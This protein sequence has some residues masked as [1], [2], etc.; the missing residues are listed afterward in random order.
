MNQIRFTAKD[1]EWSEGLKE[2]V[3]QKIIE[4]LEHHLRDQAFDLRVELSHETRGKRRHAPS[5]VLLL[6]L[7]T[8]DGRASHAL[9]ERG[10]DAYAL[11]NEVSGQ[12]GA[13]LRKKPVR[14]FSNP[15][16]FFQ[17]RSSLPFF[18]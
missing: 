15:F 2:S 7:R 3:W 6:E 12:L 8:F 16:S 4:P 13:R 17:T 11:I 9:K 10:S 5:F 18:K 1:V 14:F